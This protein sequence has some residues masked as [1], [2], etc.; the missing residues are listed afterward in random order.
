[1]SL[2]EEHSGDLSGSD[3]CRR[4]SPRSSLFLISCMLSAVLQSD[5]LHHCS[6]SQHIAAAHTGVE[7]EVTVFKIKV[8]DGTMLRYAACVRRDNLEQKSSL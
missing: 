8:C 2:S 7:Q 5:P 1:M 4:F 3:G 6:V